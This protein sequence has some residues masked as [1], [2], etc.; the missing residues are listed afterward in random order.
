M[1]GLTNLNMNNSNRVQNILTHSDCETFY[2]P[3]ETFDTAEVTLVGLMRDYF[4]NFCHCD[5]KDSISRC[6]QNHAVML[7]K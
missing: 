5:R 7:L 3:N 4:Y 1:Y 2:A 6:T